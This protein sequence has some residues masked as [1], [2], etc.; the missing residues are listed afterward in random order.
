MKLVKPLISLLVIGTLGMHPAFATSTLTPADI[1]TLATVAAIDKNEILI[2]A[3]AQNK[4]LNADIMDFA[5]M[6][7][8]QHGNNLTQILDMIKN[9]HPLTGGEADQL[10]AEGKQGL[11]KLGAMN[12]DAFA[13]AYVNAMVK[14]HE[15]ALNLIDTKLMKTAT[16]PD[17]KKFLSETRAA[18]MVHLA[19]AKKLQDKMKS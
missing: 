7:I 13:T 10:T 11:M 9:E 3:V 17:V 1:G 18:V 6:M 14:G 16:S 12:G 2:A 8:D 5:K 4:Q 19:H 15:A